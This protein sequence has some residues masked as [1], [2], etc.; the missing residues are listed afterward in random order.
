MTSFYR[1]DCSIY[2]YLCFIV[3][4]VLWVLLNVT[5]YF[6]KTYNL[7]AIE[8]MRQI[9]QWHCLR[10]RKFDLVRRCRNYR[11]GRKH[12]Q[13]QTHRNPVWTTA[14]NKSQYFKFHRPAVLNVLLQIL[15]LI[16]KWNE[17]WHVILTLWNYLWT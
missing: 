13:K 14:T 8:N 2:L 5:N 15:K 7:Q 3:H 12:W 16:Y 10:Y 17:M 6:F 1:K 9:P 11:L 4:M